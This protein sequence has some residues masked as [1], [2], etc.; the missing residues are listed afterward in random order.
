M[1]NWR[2]EH[3]MEGVTNVDDVPMGHFGPRSALSQGNLVVSLQMHSRNFVRSLFGSHFDDCRERGRLKVAVFCPYAPE[4]TDE[5]RLRPFAKEHGLEVVP[6]GF[7]LVDMSHWI[8]SQFVQLFYEI[9]RKARSAEISER[10]LDLRGLLDALALMKKGVKSGDALEMFTE[11]TSTISIIMKISIIWVEA[12]F[13]YCAE[14]KSF[15]R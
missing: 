4:Y 2:A 1:G 5:S 13:S 9:E 15:Q 6:N 7:H 14:F 10:A 3:G 12:K 8:R 11:A